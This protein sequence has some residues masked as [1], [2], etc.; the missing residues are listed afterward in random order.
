MPVAL[1]IT[2]SL[3]EIF[4]PD[5][6]GGVNN[7]L[8]HFYYSIG[9]HGVPYIF[10]WSWM[11]VIMIQS[12]LPYM[13]VVLVMRLV[14]FK[15]TRRCFD[16]SRITISTLKWCAVVS[17]PAPVILVILRVLFPAIVSVFGSRSG[18]GYD[19][20]G[21]VLYWVAMTVNLMLLGFPYGVLS[22]ALHYFLFRKSQRVT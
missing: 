1:L 16:R 6:W 8:F 22:L 19:L 11:T 17:V 10:S 20:E 5:W 13:V 15:N 7:W 21:E 4:G 2:R 9:L 12:A 14:L 3:I 18:S